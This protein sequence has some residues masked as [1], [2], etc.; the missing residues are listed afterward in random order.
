MRNSRD[1][2]K[3]LA[4]DEGESRSRLVLR[5]F[6]WSHRDA[7]AAVV[8]VSGLGAIVINALLMQ[9]GR[10]PAPMV[11]S[12]GAPPAAGSARAAVSPPVRGWLWRRMRPAPFR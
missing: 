9:T 1:K 11:N 4:A 6:N 3:V 2:R 5:A 7:I 8:A 12:A 10:H